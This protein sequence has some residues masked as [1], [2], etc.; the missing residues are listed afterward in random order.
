M[1]I[2]SLLT[3]WEAENSLHSD[4]PPS[5]MDSFSMLLI[6]VIYF[7]LIYDTFFPPLVLILVK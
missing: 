4:D 1:K 6:P 5:S 2:S 7:I 3:N